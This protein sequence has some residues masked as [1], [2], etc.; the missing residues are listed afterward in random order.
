ME[1]INSLDAIEN[2]T[3]FCGSEGST[4]AAIFVMLS[5]TKYIYLSLPEGIGTTFNIL[6]ANMN[7]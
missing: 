1:G 7:L 2:V 4:T 3:T 6:M 5:I